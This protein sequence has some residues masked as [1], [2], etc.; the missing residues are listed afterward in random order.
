MIRTLRI[1]AILVL[2][3]LFVASCK[4]SVQPSPL[5]E[6]KPGIT[7]T[8][9]PSTK[10]DWEQK[11]ENTMIQAKKEG[12]V[13]IYHN[14]RPETRIILQAFKE[15][16]GITAEFTSFGRGAEIAPRVQAEKRAEIY[17]ADLFGAGLGTII[18]SMKPISLLGPIKPL[19]IL[20]EVLD[21]NAWIG[22]KL[23]FA[24]DEGMAFRMIGVI[25][26]GIIYNTNLIKEGEITSY[27]DLLKPQ[28]RGLI[29]F[30]DPTVA[31]PGNAVVTNLGLN[32]WGKEKTVEF[33]KRLVKEQKVEIQRDNRLNLE[34][35]SK[36]KFSITIG[37]LPD[38]LVQFMDAGAPMKMAKL[39]EADHVTTAAGAIGVPTRLAHPNATTIFINWLLS[40]EGQSLFAR[41]FGGPSTRIDASTEGINTAVVPVPD[42]KYYPQTED[43]LKVQG[44]WQNLAKQAIDEAMK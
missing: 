39:R 16:Y 5:A 19:L 37:S 11:W 8:G 7:G 36:G 3:A 43:F 38:L 35:V 40:K 21:Q 34:S 29:T 24:D 25:N 18:V 42:R 6:S 26:P 4:A 23:P 17:A 15:K 14:W 33:L 32:V 10:A 20:P 13:S 1:L 22:G 2:I 41:S 31:G 12:V 30:N 44:D 9:Q 27:E 28:Y